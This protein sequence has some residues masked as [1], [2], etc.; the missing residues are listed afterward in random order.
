MRQ[1]SFPGLPGCLI[2]AGT[3]REGLEDGATLLG[4]GAGHGCQVPTGT[5]VGPHPPPDGRRAGVLP[6]GAAA[7]DSGESLTRY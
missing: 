1:L 5:V 7:E 2:R 3:G 4:E 6:G